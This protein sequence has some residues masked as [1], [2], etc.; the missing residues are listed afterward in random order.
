VQ[1]VSR[2]R[3]RAGAETALE[4]ATDGDNPRAESMRSLDHPA[5]SSAAVSESSPGIIEIEP[6]GLLFIAVVKNHNGQE[7][8]V[9][10]NP[11]ISFIEHKKKL[12]S[13]IWKPSLMM[14]RGRVIR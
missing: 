4:A 12:I 9:H 14:R 6:T 3:R 5:A 11:I 1:S 13:M 2:L 10:I 7:N 8:F